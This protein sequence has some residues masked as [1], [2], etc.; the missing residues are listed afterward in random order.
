MEVGTL[1]IDNIKPIVLSI[2][3]PQPEDLKSLTFIG[4]A[5]DSAIFWG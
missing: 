3:V 2:L 5:K 1:E 4:E